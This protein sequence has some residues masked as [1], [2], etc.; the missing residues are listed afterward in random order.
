MSIQYPKKDRGGI[1]PVSW[2][3]HH[4]FRDPPKAIHTRKKERVSTEQVGWN[5]RGDE[6]RI[7]ENILNFARGIN[8]MVVIDYNGHGAGGSKTHSITGPTPSNPYKINKAFRPPLVRQ[9]DLVPLSRLPRPYT[10]GITNPGTRGID[11]NLAEV[12]DKQIIDSAVSVVKLGDYYPA[13]IPP[14]VTY[15]MGGVVEVDPSYAITERYKDIPV[16]TNLAGQTKESLFYFENGKYT[17][18]ISAN[19]KVKRLSSNV[20]GYSKNGDQPLMKTKLELN[21]PN[22]SVSANPGLNLGTPIVDPEYEL[23][24]NLPSVSYHTVHIPT[25]RRNGQNVM[26]DIKLESNLPNTAFHTVPESKYRN[27]LVNRE[28][29]MERNIPQI[30][31]GTAI[32]ENRHVTVD[33]EMKELKTKTGSRVS[34][35]SGA[36]KRQEVENRDRFGE[37]VKINRKGNRVYT[38]IESAG[39]RGTG[40]QNGQF[41]VYGVKKKMGV[42]PGITNRI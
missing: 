27:P 14:S 37:G 19:E 12:T 11:N 3:Q 13:Y 5:I 30:S 18:S 17:S 2:D 29:K 6:T 21:N 39:T 41:A 38:N 16:S 10:V 31:I 35:S 33:G 28:Y 22:V 23:D 42:T 15:I 32:S 34:I 4:I 26:E 24:N 20:N 1:S 36:T 7:S 8:P 25:E 9:Q 40:I